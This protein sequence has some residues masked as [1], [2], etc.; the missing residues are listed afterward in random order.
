MSW[1][2]QADVLVESKLVSITKL[3]KCQEYR[4]NTLLLWYND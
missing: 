1:Q 4:D 3:T 2:K